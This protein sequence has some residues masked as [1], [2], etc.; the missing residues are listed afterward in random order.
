MKHQLLRGLAAAA[1]TSAFAAPGLAQ[2]PMEIADLFD[3]RSAGGAE[4]SP[5][6]RHVAYT[7]F[8]P[9]NVAAGEA[10]GS[11]DVGLYVASGPNEARAFVTGEG[12]V[13]GVDWTPDGQALTFLA[14]RGGDDATSLYAIALNGGEARRVLTHDTAI[15]SYVIAPDGDTVFF[16]ASPAEDDAAT[17]FTALGFRANVYEEQQRFARVYRAELSD[18]DADPEPLDADGHPSSLVLSEDGRRLAVVMAPTTLVDDSLMERDWT[19]HDTRS[20]DLLARF[21]TPG[22]IGGGA[23]SPDG[24]RFAF[25][26]AA[27]RADPTAGTL[28]VGDIGSGEFVAIARDAEQHIGDIAWADNSTVVALAA[29]GVETAIVTYDADSGDETGRT[30][31]EDFVVGSMDLHRASGRIAAIADA[32]THPNEVFVGGD[33][34]S[35]TRWTDHNPQLADIAFGEQRA[36]EYEARDGERIEGVLITPQGRAPQGGWP[37][38][39]TVHGGPEAH[40]DDG[41]LNGYSRLGHIAAGDGF[42][43]FYP[44]YRGSTGRGE[45]FAKLDHLDAPG[46]EFWDIV[47]GITAL[48]EAGLVDADRV[49]ITGGSY[50]GFASAW[51]ATIAS[52]HFAASAPS[53]ALTDLISFYGTTEIPIEMVDVH[54]MDAPWEAW[55]TYLEKSPTYNAAGSTTPTLIFHGEEDTRVDPSQSFILYRMLKM[56]SDAPVRLVTYPGEGHGNRNG[57]AQ[58]DYAHRLHRWMTHYL[59]GEGGEPPAPELPLDTLIGGGE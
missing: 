45:R 36:F 20:G 7:L 6:G 52:E 42:A 39:M 9:R 12:R 44:N 28:H 35:L 32:P 58:F 37:L 49:G 14:R 34:A 48:S 21:E 13:G 19:I 27:D 55:T 17:R 38:I 26:A 51:G 24:R 31:Y 25:L 2:Q 1:L 46:D 4:L 8:D 57:A 53:V 59:Q 41:W 3:V 22:K 43:V 11:G 40:D 10:D 29:I 15:Q 56:T 23:F 5:D 16:I 30:A 18:P 50:G 54:F 47:D 33:P